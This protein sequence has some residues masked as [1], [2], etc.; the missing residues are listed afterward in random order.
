MLGKRLGVT[1]TIKCGRRKE[2]QVVKEEREVEKINKTRS[3][4]GNMCW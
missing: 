4:Y 3:T 2:E 1:V